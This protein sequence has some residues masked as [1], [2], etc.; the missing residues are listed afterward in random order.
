MNR[1][2]YRN[3]LLRAVTRFSLFPRKKRPDP[4]VIRYLSDEHRNP[5]LRVCGRLSRHIS[6]SY[7]IIIIRIPP[8]AN[9]AE[10][11]DL[12]PA[13]AIHFQHT[14]Q[15]G[16]MSI[17]FSPSI[18]SN[19]VRRQAP[20]QKKCSFFGSLRSSALFCLNHFPDLLLPFPYIR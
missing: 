7:R 19:T 12:P 2:D 1:R 14:I 5:L 20:P 4:S 6:S 16:R 13:P 11:A 3:G 10:P 8:F 15:Q 18:T 9:F 17:F